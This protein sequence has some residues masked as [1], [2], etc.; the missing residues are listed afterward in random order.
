MLGQCLRVNTNREEWWAQQGR[1]RLDRSE[2]R[3][4]SREVRNCKG[5][6]VVG[7]YKEGRKG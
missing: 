3:E 4:D 1:V 6:T 7:C 5:K 2:G